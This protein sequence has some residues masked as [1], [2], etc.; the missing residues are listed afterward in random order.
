MEYSS[1]N[2]V[3]KELA[4]LRIHIALTTGEQQIVNKL[5][6]SFRHKLYKQVAGMATNL[7]NPAQVKDLEP[8]F[9]KYIDLQKGNKDKGLKLK[10]PV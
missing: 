4:S 6:A 2:S 5:D 9:T 3:F 10:T 1:L 7:P 8:R